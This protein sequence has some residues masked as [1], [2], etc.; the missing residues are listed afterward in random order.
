MKQYKWD[1]VGESQMPSVEGTVLR[2]FVD[3]ER[4][5][6]GRVAFTA[7]A[8]TEPHRHENEQFSMV[9]SGRLEF[10]VEGETIIVGPGD[11][12]HLQSNEFHGARALEPTVV[13]DVFSPPR[14]D[15]KQP[16]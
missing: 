5:T 11:V 10:T 1:D 13:I 15:W 8:I 6:I 4:I 3:G 9:V 7:G 2:R 12:L 16:E 14:A